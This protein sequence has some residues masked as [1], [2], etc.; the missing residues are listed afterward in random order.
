MWPIVHYFN[1]T[2]E[3]DDDIQLVAKYTDYTF[4]EILK[5]CSISSVYTV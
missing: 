5:K 2:Q 4:Q 1:L 3:Y